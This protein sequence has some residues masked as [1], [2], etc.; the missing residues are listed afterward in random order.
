MKLRLSFSKSA[1]I[2]S[3]ALTTCEITWPELCKA[4]SNPVIAPNKLQ[5]SYYLRCAGTKRS[6]TTV[7][8]QA[9]LLIIDGDGRIGDGGE[10]LKGAPAPAQVHEA[11]KAAG[12]PHLIAGT[13]SNGLTQAEIAALNAAKAAKAEQATRTLRMKNPNAPTVIPD[14]IDT[15]GL[16][17]ADLHRYRILVPTRYGRD[18]LEPLVGMV[19]STLH[20]AGLMLAP[21][22]ENLDWSHAWFVPAVPDD[23]RLGLFRCFA[24][25][26]DW[27]TPTAPSPPGQ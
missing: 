17:G 5:T 2:R 27:W 12:I 20:E 18:D 1:S 4:F 16:F 6:D 3:T 22:K 21:A 24:W 7:D 19:L 13:H 15:G 8:N 14:L 11:L 9:D 26:E 25:G 10:I 23:A